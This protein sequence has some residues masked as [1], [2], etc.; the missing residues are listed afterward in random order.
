MRMLTRDNELEKDKKTSV[1]NYS[2]L[3]DDKNACRKSQNGF[4]TTEAGLK[5][6]VTDLVNPGH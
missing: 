2:A 4:T 6:E 1:E 5:I 3:L